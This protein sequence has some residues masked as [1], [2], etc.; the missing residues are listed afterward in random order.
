MSWG[1]IPSALEA[2]LANPDVAHAAAANREGGEAELIVLRSDKPWDDP[3]EHPAL[4]ANTST[5][6]IPDL[7]SLT[8]DAAYFSRIDHARH[9]RW[10]GRRAAQLLR[11][12]KAHGYG[13]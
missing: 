11:P 1:D 4:L 3:A 2:A 13:L 9:A 6:A 5:G 12:A 8:N 7:D 10:K